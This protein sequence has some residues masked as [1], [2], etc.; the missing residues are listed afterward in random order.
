VVEVLLA[1]RRV[2]ARGLDVPAVPGA[3]PDVLPGRRDAEPADPLDDVGLLDRIA[4]L[5]EIGEPAAA[6]DPPE[7]RS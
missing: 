7:T 3:D 1:A 5:V 4:V 6:L 2:D